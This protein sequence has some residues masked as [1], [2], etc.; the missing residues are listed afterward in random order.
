VSSDDILDVFCSRRIVTN[1]AEY[2]QAVANVLA[3]VPQFESDE[4]VKES[5]W[6]QGSYRREVGGNIKKDVKVGAPS[7]NI[8][9]AHFESP[10]WEER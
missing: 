8:A 3:N 7:I 1:D 10:R 4:V 2:E 5:I 9:R 6:A